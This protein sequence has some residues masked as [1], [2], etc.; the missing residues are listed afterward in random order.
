MKMLR[1][2]SAYI[3]A[4]FLGL[5][6]LSA[7]A[8]L[9]VSLPTRLTIAVGPRE[10]DDYRV[11]REFAQLMHIERRSIRLRLIATD[12]AQASAALMQKGEADL[13][14]VRADVALPQNGQTVVVMHKNAALLVGKRGLK[15]KN[16]GDLRGKRVGLM[17][18][19]G[20]NRRLLE[21]ILKHYDVALDSL[22]LVPLALPEVAAAVSEGKID[23]LFAVGA[24]TGPTLADA[25]HAM[26]QASGGPPVFIPVEDAEAIAQKSP[27]HE[28]IEILRGIFG[29]SPPR[30]D[31]AFT[32]LSVSHR[33]MAKSRLSESTVASLTRL[34]F[35]LRPNVATVVPLASSIEAPDEAVDQAIPV[36]PGAL[37]Y[38]NSDEK[39]FFDRYGDWFYLGVMAIS[40]LGSVGAVAAGT[41]SR[42]RADPHRERVKRVLSIL[43]EGRAARDEAT[44]HAYRDELDDIVTAT[45]R[46]EHAAADEGKLSMLAF[47]VSGARAAL[48]EREAE[49]E[50]KKIERPALTATAPNPS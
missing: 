39:T 19:T 6:A 2:T 41:I 25:V 45:L 29:G 8:V 14:V 10:S 15:L 4:A 33:L 44:L 23:V 17:R 43:T 30:P 42:R 21:L 36:H 38:V 28:S 49:L 46:D 7:I 20:T 40:L 12:G 24:P 13:A 18:G 22:T 11:I 5:V 32:T 1:P 34:I 9:Y 47:A 16:V 26:V 3:L 48:F 35:A 50:K 27:I 37:A 31:E